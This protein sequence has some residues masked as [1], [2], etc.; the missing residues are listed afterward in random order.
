MNAFIEI[1]EIRGD[2]SRRQRWG[3]YLVLVTGVIGLLLGANLRDSVRFATTLYNNTQAG[4]S[5][6]YPR[7][8]LIDSEGDYIFRVQDLTVRGF[9]TVIQ[10]SIRPVGAETTARNIFDE[11]SFIRAQTFDGYRAFVVED[12]PL[13]EEEIPAQSLRY[14]FVAT[15][16]NPFLQSYPNVVA[17]IDVLVI[18]RGQAIIVTLQSNADTF[19]R[20]F[21][22]FT[23][24]L[25]DLEF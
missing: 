18:R 19:D 20:S 6:R 3:H 16:V 5:A 7:N 4:I 21:Q 8:W 14:T 2:L 22:T 1:I 23:Q 17:G 24:F 9:K 25:R 15:E 11:L 12:F 10:V 13:E